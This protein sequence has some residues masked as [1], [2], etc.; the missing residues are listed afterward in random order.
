MS[1]EVEENK[2]GKSEIYSQRIKAGKRTY[3][4][5]IKATKGSDYYL[6]IT[7]SKKRFKEEG[8]YYEKHKIFLFKED[9]A[10]FEEAIKN[11]KKY[12]QTEL[13]ANFEESSAEPNTEKSEE[14]NDT[15]SDLKW[16]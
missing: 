10:K 11:I 15:D 3:F 1:R 12:M 2:E 7:E 5:D 9:F 4:F 6:T 13:G 16:E 8:F 14:D